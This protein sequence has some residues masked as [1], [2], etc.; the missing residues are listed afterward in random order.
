MIQMYAVFDEAGPDRKRISLMTTIENGSK[1]VPR[2]HQKREFR[3]ELEA[4]RVCSV[5]RRRECDDDGEGSRRHVAHPVNR[6]NE[7]QWRWGFRRVC[8]GHD[9]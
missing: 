4:G 3:G 2:V 5:R 1:K 7:K 6:E 9:E 8:D